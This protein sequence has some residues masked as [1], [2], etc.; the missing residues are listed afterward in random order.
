M[1]YLNFNQVLDI[2]KKIISSTGGKPGLRDGE[3]LK[4]S[5]NKP[6]MTFQGE[7][8][9][10]AL[11]DKAGILCYSIIMNHPF[12]DGNKRAGHAVMEVFLIMNGYEIIADI[13][14][15]EKTILKIASGEINIKS[16][17]EWLENHIK[18]RNL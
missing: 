17:T 3:L 9:Y 5:L 1:K 18:K 7:D 14:E 6:L 2:Y 11:T 12:T 8:L 10:P 4:S 13:D 15:Q 16:F